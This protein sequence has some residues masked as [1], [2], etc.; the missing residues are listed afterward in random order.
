MNETALLL[1]AIFLVA[2]P[3]A[4]GGQTPTDVS[5]VSVTYSGD[6]AVDVEN[7]TFLW[8]SVAHEF[9]ADV[10]TQSRVDGEVCLDAIPD[11]STQ[12]VELRCEAVSLP[13]DS[14]EP[15]AVSVAEWPANLTGAQTVRMRVQST[16]GAVLATGDTT[17]TVLQRD[18]DAD[19][20]G[21]P[22]VREASGGTNPLVADSDGDGFEDGTEV[23]VYGTSPISADTDS[24]GLADPAEI[25]IGTNP[26]RADS[27]GDDLPDRREVDLGTNPNRADSDGDGLADGAEVNVHE[28][29][30][31]D[32]DTDGD[33]VDDGAEVNTHG[34]NPLQTDTDDDGLSDSLEVYTYGT[35]PNR[36]DTDGDGLSDDAEASDY[37]T[38]PATA[39]TDGDALPDGA[40]VNTHGTNPNRKDTDGDG[41]P[42]GAEVNRYGSNPTKVDTDGDGVSDAAE[43]PATPVL[44]ILTAIGVVGSLAALV[45]ALRWSSLRA[46][47]DVFDWIT[48]V[49]ARTGPAASDD[50]TG[51]E[52]A[53][54]AEIAAE[55]DTVEATVTPVADGDVD[56]DSGAAVP[57][58][59][60]S[61]EER[62][63]RLLDEHDGRIHQSNIVEE[64]DWSKAKVSRVLSKMADDDQIVKV[65]VGASNIIT[66]PDGVPTGA[67]SPFDE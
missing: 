12:A 47:H 30:P 66:H 20:D 19:G 67:S 10:R 60:L 21:L 36:L 64:T 54:G 9:T 59:F 62:I 18:A 35:D 16:E 42:D 26:N 53:K 1:L 56:V 34:T 48:T 55:S 28:T 38:D 40:E 41:L 33:A 6:G 31:L 5:V 15:V 25:E 46:G 65:N 17:V 13:A 24:D 43:V 37:Q 22:N 29:D 57:A 44:T 2:S 7:A 11:G 50:T 27:D 14:T 39:D 52:S 45:V 3:V 58:E 23:Q 51:A 32:P 4:A 63:L 61:N 49:T 8:Q